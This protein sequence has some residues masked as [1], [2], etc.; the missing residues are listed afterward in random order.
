M[1]RIRRGDMV[2]VIAGKYKGA[3]GR[4]LAVLRDKDM[5]LVENVNVKKRHVKPNARM[6]QGGIIEREAPIHACKV[7]PLD[8]ETGLPTRVRIQTN[9]EGKKER[10]AVKSGAVI[11][12]N[13]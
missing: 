12:A 6:P 7:M 11:V 1:Q 13:S 3:K 4:I 5:V 9:E 10:V 2:Q 8:P